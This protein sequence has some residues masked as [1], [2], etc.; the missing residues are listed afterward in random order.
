MT[1]SVNSPIIKSFF[2]VL[3]Q[4]QEISMSHHSLHPYRYLWPETELGNYSNWKLCDT[5]Q[6]YIRDMPESELE[7][8][9]D[10]R[11]PA[12]FPSPISFVATAN[13]QYSALEKVVGAS[14]VNRFPYILALSFCKK[15]LSKRHHARRVFTEILD[16]N[17]SVAV[18]FLP[19]GNVLDKV[20]NSIISVPEEQTYLRIAHSGLPTRRAMTNNSAVF[21]GAYMVYEATPVKP[22]K[23]LEGNP[24]FSTP[25]IDVGSH[26]I[27]FLEVQAIQLR[28]DIAQ[29]A[30]QIHWRSLPAWEPQFSVK[31]GPVRS[32]PPRNDGIYQKGY[33]PQ[34]AFPSFGTIAFEAD[35]FKYG[36]AIKYLP[37][38][39]EDQVEI[40]NDKARWPCFFPCSAG[41]ITTWAAEGIPNLMP[42][43]STTMVSRNPLTIAPCIS[44]AAINDRYAPRASLNIL[45]KTGK[46]GCG[47]PFISDTVVNAIRY[48]GNISFTQDAD[49]MAHSG[50]SIEYSDCGP[51]LSDLPIHFDCQVV[52]EIRLG[53]HIMFLG[54]V[55]RIYVRKDVNPCNSLEWYPFARIE[56]SGS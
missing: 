47:V 22:G 18:Q 13:D 53:T 12:F 37:P 9:S 29:G 48:T 28:K 10:S 3:N 2:I 11:W 39:P 8:S 35:T 20:M 5:G 55:R 38:L 30:S 32:L 36:M 4:I 49:K 50:L 27:Y 52:G 17:G 26:R 21:E 19:P 23:D 54:E 6:S 51:I 15:D 1:S 43:G 34:Y 16:D 33:T 44:Y 40:D 31:N 24:I 14:I 46:F 56:P 41:V 42:C 25:W 7:L 45:R